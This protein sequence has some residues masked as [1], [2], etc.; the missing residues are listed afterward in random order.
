MSNW[1]QQPRIASEDDAHLGPGLAQPP[2]QQLEDGCGV[3]GRI[4]ATGPKVGTQEL[5]AAEDVLRQV[6]T[7]PCAACLSP[8]WPACAAACSSRTAAE[9]HFN[10]ADLHAQTA[11]VIFR[12]DKGVL[13][14]I[15]GA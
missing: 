10:E 11:G 13:D 8:E 3:P 5:L 1:R 6:A 7:T 15:P 14:G 12:K 2:H 4:D 9:E